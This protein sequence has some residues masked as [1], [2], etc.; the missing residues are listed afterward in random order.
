M[1]AFAEDE[2]DEAKKKAVKT[3]CYPLTLWRT[4]VMP[5]LPGGTQASSSLT[6]K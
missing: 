5:P 2:Q 4:Q 6:A 3:S 1:L